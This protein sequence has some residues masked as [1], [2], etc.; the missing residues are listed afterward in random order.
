MDDSSRWVDLA[1]EDEKMAELAYR[2]KLYNQV[3]FHCQQGAEKLLK[4]FLVEK[5]GR[6]PKVHSLLELLGVASYLDQ[7]L[8]ALRNDCLYLDQFYVS[9]RYPD[10]PLGNLAQGA[11][12]E[13]DAKRAIDSF[14]QIK[15]TITQ[16]LP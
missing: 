12:N 3:C 4:A 14:K 10:A 15:A 5:D 16:K 2:E 8:N 11:P 6:F 1:L 9:T 13:D 7:K